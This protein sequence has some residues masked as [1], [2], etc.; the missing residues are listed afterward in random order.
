MRPYL[1]F[2]LEI[3]KMLPQGMDDWRAHRPLGITCAAT[4]DG[5]GAPRLWYGRGEGNLPASQLSRSELEALVAHLE[6]A[7][8]A[9]VTLLTWN[10][11]GFDFDVLAEESGQLERCAR[12]ALDHVDMMFHILCLRGHTLALD[13]AAKGMGLPG[14][15][16]GMSGALAPR[17]WAEGK[18]AIV[19]EYVAQDVRTTLGVARAVERSGELRWSSE[20]G[21]RQALPLPGGWLNVRQAL[22]LPEPDVSWMRNPRRRSQFMSW[23]KDSGVE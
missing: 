16:P 8:R 15:P 17:Y 13:R 22:A 4:F 5:E 23:M 12:L 10:G 1:A 14:K 21:L 2:D 9:G 6:D 11:L 3:L 18:W 7:A 20:R 19:L